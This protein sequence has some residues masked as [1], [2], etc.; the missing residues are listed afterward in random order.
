MKPRVLKEFKQQA[1]QAGVELLDAQIA[2]SGHFKLTLRRADGET[3]KYTAPQSPSDWRASIK[4]I[5][6]WKR[7]AK[8]QPI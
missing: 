7:F 4:R 2:N 8:G 3:L 5:C 1:A 6:D